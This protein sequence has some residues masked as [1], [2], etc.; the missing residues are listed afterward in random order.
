LAN[1]GYPDAAALYA[2]IG[3]D[4]IT[5]PAQGAWLRFRRLIVMEGVSYLGGA[6]SVEKTRQWQQTLIAH[7]D[8]FEASGDPI[9]VAYAIIRA[10]HAA[11]TAG[12][13][14]GA[15]VDELLEPLEELL[16]ESLSRAPT[17]NR[18]RFELVRSRLAELIGGSAA[19]G[20]D[21]LGN[22]VRGRESTDGERFD[23]WYCAHPMAIAR[24]DARA[25]SRGA[26]EW[27][28]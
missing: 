18:A 15:T 22:R 1:R 19:P 10:E 5:D 17:E 2:G 9:A 14:S 6:P 8:R 28:R 23:E 13:T 25:Y 20:M 26:D 11:W 4:S 12:V 21:K 27:R 7:L 24:W 16:K 3:Q